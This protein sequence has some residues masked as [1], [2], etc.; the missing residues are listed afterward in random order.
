VTVIGKTD[1]NA[2]VFVNSE[3]AVLDKNGN[4]KKTISVFP[5]K[6]KNYYKIN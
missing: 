6:T 1:S 5:G 4:F 3:L 2:A